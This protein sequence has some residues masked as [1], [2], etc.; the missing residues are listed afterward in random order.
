MK[1]MDFGLQDFLCRSGFCTK[2]CGKVGVFVQS[3]LYAP[4]PL[5]FDETLIRVLEVL[6]REGRVSTVRAGD[7]LTWTRHSSKTWRSKSSRPKG[8]RSTKL[9]RWASGTKGLP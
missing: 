9:E 6:Q 7:D 1:H 4:L 3:R 5:T 8:W 2:D